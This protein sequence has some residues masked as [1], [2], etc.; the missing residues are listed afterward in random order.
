MPNEISRTGQRRGVLLRAHVAQRVKQH[1]TGAWPGLA[2]LG[3]VLATQTGC[4]RTPDGVLVREIADQ[5]FRRVGIEKVA[6]L[7]QNHAS[8]YQAMTAEGRTAI[9]PMLDRM[10][11]F[12]RGHNQ[13]AL[14][15]RTDYSREGSCVDRTITI[16]VHAFPHAAAERAHA[17]HLE[18]GFVV[19]G[20]H[21]LAVLSLIGVLAEECYHDL[22]SLPGYSAHEE[23]ES[24]LTYYYFAKALIADHGQRI[25]AVPSYPNA[26]TDV[27]QTYADV[28]QQMS[29]LRFV[30]W[31]VEPLSPPAATGAAI[32]E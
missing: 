4:T 6:L 2:W 1:V 12:L 25:G 9:L 5:E 13:R 26:A 8:I 28:L 18:R 29:G 16:G 3:V 24:R 30:P 11:D 23:W 19:A 21:R 15:F 31:Y 32:A 22:R 27:Y 17:G 20:G 14:E 10:E 7:R